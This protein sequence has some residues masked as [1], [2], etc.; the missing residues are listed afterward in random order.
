[1]AILPGALIL[2]SLLKV[3]IEAGGR[4]SQERAYALASVNIEKL[5]GVVNSGETSDMVA[6]EGGSLLDMGARVVAIVSPDL[7]RVNLL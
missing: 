5:L 3:A 1:M 4:I 2:F 6:T 7:R